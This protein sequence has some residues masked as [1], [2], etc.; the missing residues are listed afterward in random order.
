MKENK[1]VTLEHMKVFAYG[2]VFFLYAL[3]TSRAS[4][5]SEQLKQN[6]PGVT[7]APVFVHSI[8]WSQMPNISL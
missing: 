8:N 5:I 4:F 7:I 3:A 2:Y 1:T 6:H